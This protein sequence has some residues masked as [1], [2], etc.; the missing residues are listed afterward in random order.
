MDMSCTQSV[1]SVGI[2]HTPFYQMIILCPL[3]FSLVP[4]VVKKASKPENQ[5]Y[6]CENQIY[7][8][9]SFTHIHESQIYIVES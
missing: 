7:N 8:L 3:C 9:E 1:G 6:N 5:T 4:L 2:S